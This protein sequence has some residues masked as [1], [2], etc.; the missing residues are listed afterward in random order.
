[1]PYD[2]NL[3]TT[4]LHI[5]K[6]G[7]T[8]VKRLLGIR[9]F[10]NPNPNVIPSPQHLNC[11]RLRIQLGDPKY[12]SYFKF[13]FVRNPWTR[14]VS[15]YFWRKRLQRQ[16]IDMTFREFADYATG[17]VRGDCYYSQPLGDHFIP[18]VEYTTDVDQVFR[19]E[20]FADGLKSAAR[21]LGIDIGEVPCRPV[22]TH[23][24]Y[25]SLYDDVSRALVEDIYRQDIEAFCY[26]FEG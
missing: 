12:D 9:H 10:D 8:T 4:F 1:M 22:R 19:F 17:F 3:K 25:W 16:A 21:T 20:A 23:I 26:E 14:L 15:E 24:D 2:D 11:A 7:G 18:Q 5:P 13:T 6:T